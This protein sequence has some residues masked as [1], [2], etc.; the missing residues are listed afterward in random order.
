MAKRRRNVHNKRISTE[1]KEVDQLAQEYIEVI[2]ESIRI[3]EKKRKRMRTEFRKRAKRRKNKLTPKQ[4]DLIMSQKGNMSA[5]ECAEW[6]YEKMHYH[7]KV[8]RQT[9]WW[10]WNRKSKEESIDMLD[11][12]DKIEEGDE[13]IEVYIE[14]M[15]NKEIK[16]K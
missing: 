16:V 2:D 3:C 9:V 14:K 13:D 1:A 6:F 4:I 10:H 15:E 5:A 12:L 8:T 11:L 7:F